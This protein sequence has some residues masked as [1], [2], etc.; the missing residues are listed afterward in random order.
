MGTK[1]REAIAHIIHNYRGWRVSPRARYWLVLKIQ[2]VGIHSNNH[3]NKLLRK[4]CVAKNIYVVCAV[5]GISIF[6][7]FEYGS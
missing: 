1:V 3:H 2:F 4:F 5:W 7:A 6:V